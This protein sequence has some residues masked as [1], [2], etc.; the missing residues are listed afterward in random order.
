M[1]SLQVEIELNKEAEDEAA[2]AYV[3]Q[4]MQNELGLRP[5]VL[6]VPFGSLPRFEMKAKRF[7]IKE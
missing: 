5:E 7:H 4:T 3:T 6:V 2:Q 1:K